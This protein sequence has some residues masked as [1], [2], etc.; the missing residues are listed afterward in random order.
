MNIWETRNIVIYVAMFMYNYGWINWLLSQKG[1][2]YIYLTLKL[3]G[4][5]LDTGDLCVNTGRIFGCNDVCNNVKY[6][7]GYSYVFCYT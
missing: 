3:S 7:I 2:S 5:Q 4:M 1:T 6:N